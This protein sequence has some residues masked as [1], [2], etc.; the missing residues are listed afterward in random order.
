MLLQIAAAN[1]SDENARRWQNDSLCQTN[2]SPT[3]YSVYAKFQ[4]EK[5]CLVK[6]FAFLKN[7]CYQYLNFVL[8]VTYIFF[9]TSYWLVHNQLSWSNVLLISCNLIGQLCLSEPSHSSRT[10]KQYTVF[11]VHKETQHWLCKIVWH[12]LYNIL[13][14]YPSG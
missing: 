13:F 11:F 1:G 10:V 3:C 9:F 2:M 14:L 7:V 8:R 12:S 5:H 4:I 6:H